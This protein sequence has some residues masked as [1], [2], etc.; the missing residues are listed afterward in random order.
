VEEVK[1]LCF[2]CSRTK[3]CGFSMDAMETDRD[4]IHIQM[5]FKP[6]ASIKEIAGKLKSLTAVFPWKEYG[7]YLK[8]KFRK[9]QTFWSDGHFTCTAGDAST[10]I[11]GNRVENRGWTR[12]ISPQQAGGGLRH[13]R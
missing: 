2:R 12:P 10:E 5:D 7:D 13:L 4:H 11:I 1:K 3:N 6:V 8:T 9:E